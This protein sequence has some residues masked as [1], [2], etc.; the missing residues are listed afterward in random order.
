MR[1]PSTRLLVTFLTFGIVVVIA[2]L[3]LAYRR[4]SEDANGLPLCA[5]SSHRS[6]VGVSLSSA[7][8]VIPYCDVVR[9]ASTHNNRLICVRGIY[10]F[11]M[12]NSAL[13]DPACRNEE[14]WT[15]VESEPSSNFKS[16]S[17]ELRRNQPA[18][19]VFLGRFSGP[20]N[21]GYGHLNGYR[22]NLL[23]LRVDEM[24]PLPLNGVDRDNV[25]PNKS[26]Q[27]TAR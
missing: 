7:L 27:L 14:S 16:S 6:L 1:L 2:V 4:P 5:T 13:D 11:N 21:E 10:S 3:W 12:E 20:N 26:L 19:V 17:P 9:G 15:W 22:Y 24:K 25:P 18:E 8:P 23:V